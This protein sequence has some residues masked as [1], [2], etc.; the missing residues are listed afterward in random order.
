MNFTVA[1]GPVRQG[2]E[3]DRVVARARIRVRTAAAPAGEDRSGLGRTEGV[4]RR[5]VTR[6]VGYGRDLGQGR[7]DRVDG[8]GTHREVVAPKHP[9]RAVAVGPVG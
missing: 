7:Y 2:V 5:R 3:G 6:I 1:V 8:E 9:D 4:A